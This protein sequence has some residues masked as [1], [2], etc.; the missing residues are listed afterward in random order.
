MTGPM[1]VLFPYVLGSN[2]YYVDIEFALNKFSMKNG[3]AKLIRQWGKVEFPVVL[4]NINDT[5]THLTSLLNMIN[6][7]PRDLFVVF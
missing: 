3:W 2:Y 7:V 1:S 6:E 4:E 5:L